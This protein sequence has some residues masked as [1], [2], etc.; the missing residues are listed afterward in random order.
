MSGY[1]SLRGLADFMARHQQSIAELF[2][3][4]QAKL[5]KYSTIRRMTRE[6]DSQRVS[7]VFHRW[8]QQDALPPEAAMAVD[9]KALG[10]TLHDCYGKHQDFVT[11][12]SACLQ[13]YGWVVAQESVHNSE[14]SEIVSVRRLIEHLEVNGA[15]YTLDALHCQKNRSCHC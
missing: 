1:S 11:V 7:Q 14:E 10:S 15:W 6:V 4:N 3:L 13:Q 12:V 2:G 9:G 8:A 5:P